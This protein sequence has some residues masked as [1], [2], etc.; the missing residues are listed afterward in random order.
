MH[1]R[2]NN[3]VCYNKLFEILFVKWAFCSFILRNYALCNEAKVLISLM[4]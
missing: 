4:T 2:V 3:V 1:L